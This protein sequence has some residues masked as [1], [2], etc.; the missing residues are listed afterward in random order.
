M[1]SSKDDRDQASD[2]PLPA[3]LYKYRRPD[4]ESLRHIILSNELWAAK[5]SS[6]NDPFDCFPYIDLSGSLEEA[7]AY[8]ELRERRLGSRLTPDQRTGLAQMIATHGLGAIADQAGSE[9]WR[10]SVD[11]FGIISL[12]EDS[13]NILMWSHYAVDHTGVCL[14]FATDVQPFSVVGA[15]RYVSKRP[16]FRPLA[17]D[18]N[19]LMERILL[20]KAEVWRYEREW[21]HFRIKEGAGATAFPPTALRAVILGPAVNPAFERSLRELIGGRE[22]PLEV[23]RAAF[24]EQNY[25][26]HLE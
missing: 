14:E 19:G 3:R 15:V 2:P 26:L 12:A 8:I 11:Q 16:T 13:L 1:T 10:Q 4:L 6:F 9:I 24:D 25:R 20:H 7:L 5:P 22:Q 23:R 18:R 17:P 21:R